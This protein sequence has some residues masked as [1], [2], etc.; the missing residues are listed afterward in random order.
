MKVLGGEKILIAWPGAVSGC[1]RRC[2]SWVTVQYIHL[3]GNEIETVDGAVNATRQYIGRLSSY[4]TPLETVLISFCCYIARREIVVHRGR[5]CLRT[6]NRA[7]TATTRSGSF[8]VRAGTGR[9]HRWQITVDRPGHRPLP[10]FLKVLCR[11]DHRAG[12]ICCGS[13]PIRI[14]RRGPEPFLLRSWMSSDMPYK[15]SSSCAHG[16]GRYCSLTRRVARMA[17]VR[18]IDG[19]VHPLGASDH[20][21]SGIAT[22]PR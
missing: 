2:S 22:I 12:R 5:S 3:D 21:P 7:W 14:N 8:L 13:N 6:W 18:H 15:L 16:I 9:G 19:L 1:T 17:E 20:D 10:G 4:Q 11:G